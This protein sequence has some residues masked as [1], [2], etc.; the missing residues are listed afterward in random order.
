MNENLTLEE[1]IESLRGIGVDPNSGWRQGKE[2]NTSD[3]PTLEKAQ[4][5]ALKLQEI[6]EMQITNDHKK[7]LELRETIGRITHGGGK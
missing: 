7:V 4:Q 5:A 3:V 1:A 6:L 2:V